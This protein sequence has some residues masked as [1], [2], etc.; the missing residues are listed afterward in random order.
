[1]NLKV[2]GRKWTWVKD[3]SANFLGHENSENC[4]RLSCPHSSDSFLN[5]SECSVKIHLLRNHQQHIFIERE[6]GRFVGPIAVDP[7]LLWNL[8]LSPLTL[9]LNVAKIVLKMSA[10]SIWCTLSTKCFRAALF[11]LFI[12]YLQGEIISVDSHLVS[13]PVYGTQQKF[14]WLNIKS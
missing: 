7:S 8:L 10:R 4:T 5:Y 2:G 14:K 11:L 12:M 3:H 1:M 13:C 6:T 9:I